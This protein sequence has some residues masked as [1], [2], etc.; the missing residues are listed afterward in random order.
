MEGVGL[1]RGGELLFHVTNVFVAKTADQAAEKAR[2]LR[3]GPALMR[4]W[5]A[6]TKS[7]GLSCSAWLTSMPRPVLGT[8]MAAHLEAGLRG[9]ADEGVA[10]ETLAALHRFQQ[11][12]IGLVGQLEIN[13]KRGVEIGKGFED[14]RDAVETCAASCLNSCSVMTNS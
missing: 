2:Q 6:E 7:R 4:A 10:A 12:G 5:Q 13:R 8:G 11:I 1:P 3:P 9:Q 14:N